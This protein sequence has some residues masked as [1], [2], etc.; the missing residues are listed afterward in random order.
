MAVSASHSANSM[1]AL[2]KETADLAKLRASSTYHLDYIFMPRNWAGQMTEMTVGS[3]EDS[4]GNKL[5]DHVTLVV[6]IDLD[7]R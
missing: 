3:F 2:A 7:K 1:A 4:C 5:I 6:D